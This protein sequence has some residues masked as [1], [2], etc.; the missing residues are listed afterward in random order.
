MKNV[1]YNTEKNIEVTLNF[2]HDNI[3]VKHNWRDFENWLPIELIINIDGEV[4]NIGESCNAM[5]T[6]LEY[7]DL[8]QGLKSIVNCN[9]DISFYTYNSSESLFSIDLE[10]L[11]EDECIE[12]VIWINLAAITEGNKVGYDK[13]VRFITTIKETEQ[14]Y[15]NLTKQYNQL[16]K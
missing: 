10:L 5:M 13:G 8:I 15:V 4:Y 14:F 1:L 9:N 3:D 12:F 7:S 6:V 2:L 11:K 16:I